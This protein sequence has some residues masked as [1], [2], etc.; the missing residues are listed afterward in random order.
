M[1]ADDERASAQ[2]GKNKQYVILFF[3]FLPLLKI[4]IRNHRNGHSGEEDEAH[5]EDTK[6]VEDKQRFYHPALAFEVGGEISE[7]AQKGGCGDDINQLVIP[8][9]GDGEHDQNR[10]AGQNEKRNDM[11]EVSLAHDYPDLGQYSLYRYAAM[12]P[13]THRA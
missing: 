13:L 2:G 1:F 3:S 6:A 9:N 5:V 12:S 7:I 8:L 11:K 10:R 4:R